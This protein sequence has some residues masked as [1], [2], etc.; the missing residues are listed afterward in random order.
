MKIKTRIFKNLVLFI[1]LILLSASVGTFSRYVSMVYG[2]TIARV[3][4]FGHNTKVEMKNIKGKPGDVKI[5]PIEITNTKN[6]KVCEV[7]QEFTIYI[8]RKY[9][10]NLPLNINLYKDK[11]C[12]ELIHISDKVYTNEDFKFEAG[13]NQTKKY[14]LKIEWPSNSSSVDNAFEIDYFTIDF[15]V[16]QVD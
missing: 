1:L 5:I 4:L 6:D 2:N 8:N 9:G 12:T 3:A 10:K 7:S 13:K 14:Y 11:D 16:V 15:R